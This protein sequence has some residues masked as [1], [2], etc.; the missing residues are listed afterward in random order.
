[1]I[2]KPTVLVY[3][4]YMIMSKW[5]FGRENLEDVMRIRKAIF[6]DE[7]G[8]EI[9]QDDDD[10]TALH[11]LVGE[12]DEYYACGRI[13]DNDGEFYIGMVVVDNRVRG[14]K[15]GALVV[16]L[17]IN[18]G[19]EL[20]ADKIYVNARAFIVGFY[21]TLNFEVCGELF[22]DKNGKVAIPMVL[23]KE[24]SPLEGGCDDCNGCEKGCV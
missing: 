22:T 17:L 16:R 3:N 8:L 1:M 13:F 18:R 4:E 11:I 20:L 15:L 12:D 24:N 7:L 23:L 9:F 21:E 5:V 6:K 2:D 14:E 19:F 10:D